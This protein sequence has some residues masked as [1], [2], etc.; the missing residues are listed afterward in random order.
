MNIENFK[1]YGERDSGTNLLE[2]IFT[3]NSFYH[4]QESAAFSIPQSKDY[5][6]KHWFG[7]NSE[8][9]QKEGQNT[10]F[11]GIV[12]DPYDWIIALFKKKHHI[13]PINYSIDNFL[14]GE[15]YSID[16]KKS[17]PTYGREVL[18][19]R[20]WKTGERYK[21]IF[22][23][24]KTK[25]EYLLDKMPQ[26]AQYYKLIR[27]EDLCVNHNE[28]LEQISNTYNLSFNKNYL[29][30]KPKQHYPLQSKIVKI[31]NDNI[32]WDV[33]QQVGYSKRS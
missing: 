18:G 19:D 5:G 25:L 10:L 29:K 13:P 23:L 3:G 8:D 33:E 30:P 27:Y 15:W 32:D 21:N 1:I 14:L 31:I 12:R 2:A 7:F 9:I 20:N 17:S 11:L 26:L 28:F 16:H 4:K 6:W 24:R 22:E